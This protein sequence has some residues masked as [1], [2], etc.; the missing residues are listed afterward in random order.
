MTTKLLT[1]KSGQTEFNTVTSKY[2]GK[3]TVNPKYLCLVQPLPRLNWGTLQADVV[4]RNWVTVM[5]QSFNQDVIVLVA[6]YVIIPVGE[7]A[8]TELNLDTIEN[9]LDC[10]EVRAAMGQEHFELLQQAR[11][12]IEKHKDNPKAIQATMECFKDD[13]P[14]AYA[15]YMQLLKNAEAK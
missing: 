7:K 6:E 15:E 2:H 13:V 8:D 10:L 12:M 5:G 4:G 14:E 9:T 1:D 11:S 3:D